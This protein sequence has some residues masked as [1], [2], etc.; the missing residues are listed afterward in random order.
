[1]NK[2][3]LNQ[4]LGRLL[5]R[6][7]KERGFSQKKLASLSASCSHSISAPYVSQVERGKIQP[8][9][10]ALHTFSE[11]LV[12]PREHLYDLAGMRMPEVLVETHESYKKL[13]DKGLQAILEGKFQKA[14]ELFTSSLA[15]AKNDEEEFRGIVNCAV[16]QMNLG[17]LTTAQIKIQDALKEYVKRVG[18]EAIF[19]GLYNLAQVFKFAENYIPASSF[20]RDALRLAMKMENGALKGMAYNALGSIHECAGEFEEAVAY[21]DEALT[22]VKITKD[23]YSNAIVLANKGDTLVECGKFLQGIELLIQADGFLEKT[24]FTYMKSSIKLYLVKAY[25]LK[26]DYE[27]AMA[28]EGETWPVVFRERYGDLM[29]VAAFYRWRIA[30]ERG[31]MVEEKKSFKLLLK[32]S[33]K[34][35]KILAEMRQ[36]RA[37][38][39]E[40]SK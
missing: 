22:F 7:R 11:I 24:K 23:D 3:A 29:F 1:M 20:A 15:V 26:R 34:T 39:L 40:K 13:R 21:F 35:Q 9:L 8:T 19:F 27:R 10:N 4:E 37:Y 38:L 14:L 33:E 6:V 2:P 17:W 28:I 16:A 32:L 36:F 30:R 18:E 12:I 5:K 31:D 25:Y